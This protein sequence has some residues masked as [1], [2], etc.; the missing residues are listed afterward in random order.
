MVL[1]NQMFDMRSSIKA[2]N[3]YW[4]DYYLSKVWMVAFELYSSFRPPTDVP[5]G[6]ADKFEKY[7]THEENRIRK[8]LEDIHYDIDARETVYIVVGP[9][10]IEKVMRDL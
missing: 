9:G 7:V 8:N 2:E 6:L 3:R 4:V 10:R 1:F 5:D